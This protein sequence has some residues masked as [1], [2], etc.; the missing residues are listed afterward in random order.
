MDCFRLFIIALIEY[1]LLHIPRLE[2]AA[3]AGRPWH[4][5]WFSG[6]RFQ[7]TDALNPETCALAPET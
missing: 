5:E 4:S 2:K 6:V 1:R 3:R 7:E